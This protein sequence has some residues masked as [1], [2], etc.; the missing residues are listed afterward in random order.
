MTA[1][2]CGL[3]LV[4]LG[5]ALGSDQAGP[6]TVG[7]DQ[8]TVM[9]PAYVCAYDLTLAA[10]AA[11]PELAARSAEVARREGELRLAELGVSSVLTVTTGV[12]VSQNLL[13]D[14][15]ARW[16]TSLQMDAGLGYRY[17][18]VAIVR[19]RTALTT[20]LKRE[21][22][23]RRADVLSALINLSRLRAAERLSAQTDAVAVEAESLAASVRQSAA[24]AQAAWAETGVAT[25]LE[26]NPETDLALNIRE[27]DLAAAR[28]RAT[29]HGRAEEASAAR[30]E[31]AR[32]GIEPPGPYVFG[33]PLTS[34][35]PAACLVP[36][37]GPV[38]RA[39]GPDLPRPNPHTATERHL[40]EH[41]ADLA[42]ALHR[43]AT[44]GPLRDFSM[45]AHYQEGGARVLAELELDGGRPAA[46]VNLRLREAAAHNWGVGVA[47]TIRL[48]DSMG[49]ALTSAAEQLETARAALAAFDATLTTRVLTEVTTAETAWLQ[50]AF[51]AEAVSI[52]EGRLALATEERE[53]TRAEQVLSRAIDA[54]ER[55]YQAYL[56]AVNRYL[57]E[58]DLPWSSLLVLE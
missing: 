39:G 11:S 31:L 28:A 15:E 29:A 43:R 1:A 42:A 19:A 32:L 30:T 41:A 10:R 22:D 58:F 45:T 4:P 33:S 53:H 51:A 27:L 8:I 38:N 18:E 55:E 25:D 48:D 47:A 24:T 13:R 6:P 35:G 34:T 49:A 36:A 9:T 54:L 52:A 14:D 46:G 5:S 44:F 16:D 3:A 50:L 2:V 20:A 12:D 17:D 26:A 23:Q 37:E 57:A 21:A 56:R 7:P 40:L